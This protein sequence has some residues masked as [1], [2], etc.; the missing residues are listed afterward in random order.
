MVNNSHIYCCLPWVRACPSAKWFTNVIVIILTKLSRRCQSHFPDEEACSQRW[1]DLLLLLCLDW[2][3]GLYD[4]SM[5]FLRRRPNRIDGEVVVWKHKVLKKKNQNT[6][7][8]NGREN[9]VSLRINSEVCGTSEPL[10]QGW[11]QNNFLI[12]NELK[13]YIV[14]RGWRVSWR[15]LFKINAQIMREPMTLWGVQYPRDCKGAVSSQAAVLVVPKS[16]ALA[17][18]SQILI[19]WSPIRFLVW[20]KFAT[21]KPFGWHSCTVFWINWLMDSLIYTRSLKWARDHC[22][23]TYSRFGGK[24]N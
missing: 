9:R 7:T 17:Q 8:W 15:V 1:G 11:L 16:Q 18:N 20:Q 24:Q 22:C 3:L 21:W 23:K 19:S 13:F 2:T 14:I 5:S 10:C 6:K 4:V 12:P